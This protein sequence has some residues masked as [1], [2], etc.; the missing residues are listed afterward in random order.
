[1]DTGVKKSD[2]KASLLERLHNP[3][4]LRGLVTAVLVLAGYACVYWPLNSQIAESSARLAAEQK[5]LD[6]ARDVEHLRAQFKSFKGRLPEKSD[7]NEW[8]QYV[9]DGI[10]QLP[11]KLV[12]LDSDPPRD[13]GP[14][15]A[16]AL[17]IELEGTFQ[18]LNAFLRW[19]E[20]NERLFRAD[21][22]KI[23]PHRKGSG[24]LV[25][26]LTVLGMMG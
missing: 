1:M 4:Q 6:L 20:G 19:L 26:Q 11:V 13:V 21:A 9:L 12:T 14:Y 8:V 3:T 16:V 22:V 24:V 7:A 18:D 10:R 17:R 5:S 2:L 25:M 15:K 23:A